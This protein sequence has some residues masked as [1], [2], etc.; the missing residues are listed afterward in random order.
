MA[1]ST[2]DDEAAVEDSTLATT[3]EVSEAVL[4]CTVVLVVAMEEEET[5]LDDV[6]EETSTRLV[7]GGTALL[8]AIVLDCTIKLLDAVSDALDDTLLGSNGDRRKKVV[9]PL[10]PHICVRSPA[11]GVAH[12]ASLV[13]SKLVTEFPQKHWIPVSGILSSACGSTEENCRTYQSQRNA[14]P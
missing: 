3:V 1:T 13:A 14:S 2:A 9:Y 11:Q 7:I 12:D 10:P 6:E 8:R 5:R 4:T